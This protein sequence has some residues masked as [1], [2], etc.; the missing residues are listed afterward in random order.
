MN[1]TGKVEKYL[2]RQP[3]E[4]RYKPAGEP[5]KY[6]DAVCVIPAL[7]EFEE[8]NNLTASL[9]MNNP[10]LL[11]HTYFL[12]V[13]NNTA[14]SANEVK[15]NNKKSIELLADYNGVLNLG[16]IDA[17][18][19]ENSFDDKNGGVGL[20][21]KIGM[22]YTL[23]LFDY[24]C[25]SK[26][27]IICLDADCT[28][29]QDY[30][31]SVYDGFSSDD[32]HAGYVNFEHVLDSDNEIN[33]AIINYEIFLRYYVLGLK[34]A[35][36]PFAFHTIGSTMICDY[37]SYINIGGMNK[38]KAGEDFYFMEK[39]AKNYKIHRLAG[40]TVYPSSRPS[41]RVPFGTG[42][43]VN[44]FLSKIRDEYL[45]YNPETFKLLRKWNET[46]LNPKSESSEFYAA[47]AKR[48]D[49]RV[50]EFLSENNFFEDWNKIVAHSNKPEQLAKQKIFW[51]DGF[52]T[53]KFVH[54]MRER[55]NKD[56]E[57]FSALNVLLKLSGFK[58]CSQLTPNSAIGEQEKTLKYLRELA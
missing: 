5:D 27:I 33:R 42:Q 21:R 34:Y 8:I 30:L 2:S 52:R 14:S 47:E 39:L 29:S 13:V 6:F 46:F 11:T 16:V 3:D 22:D 17:S 18:T 57:T 38:R 54:F 55:G 51:F 9:E 48:I 7:A 53:L 10:E 56:L 44:R 32:A 49:R 25:K 36:S 43:R 37:E 12:F 23:R 19:G 45:L 15:E 24:K 4:L 31:T 28:V 26:K 20:A 1:L 58:E 40:G 41:W 35:G 50:Y